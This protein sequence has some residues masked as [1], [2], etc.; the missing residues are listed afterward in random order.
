VRL[1]D[2]LIMTVQLNIRKL[3]QVTDSWLAGESL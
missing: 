2:S 1:L 3:L